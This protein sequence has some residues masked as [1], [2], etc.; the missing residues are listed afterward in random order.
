LAKGTGARFLAVIRKSPETWVSKHCHPGGEFGF[1]LEGAVTAATE[2]E[3]EVVLDA[4]GT[5]AEGARTVVFRVLK[6][7]QPMVVAV[8]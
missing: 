5:P 1:V 3:P 2:G 6:N 4:G 8:E 7:G